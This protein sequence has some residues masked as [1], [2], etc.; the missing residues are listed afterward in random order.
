M[1]HDIILRTRLFF[2]DVAHVV[3][4][5]LRPTGTRPLSAK[6]I[7]LVDLED[8]V[9]LDAVPLVAMAAEAAEVATLDETAET[10]TDTGMDDAQSS[11]TGSAVKVHYVLVDEEQTGV[12]QAMPDETDAPSPALDSGF[13]TLDSESSPRH[14]L[15]FVDPG[16]ADHEKLIDG[17]ASEDPN[18]RLDV[19]FL[20][21]RYD[22]V[23][24]IT[25]VLSE[26]SGL[27]AV[28][29]V[30]H[31]TDGAVKLGNTWLN[32]DNL[33]A[34]AGLVAGWGWSLKSDADLLFYG[35]DLAE[36]EEGQ[37]LVDSL[38]TLTGADVAA[39]TDD[40]GHVFFGG[41][42]ELEYSTGTIETGL[43]FSIEVQQ[44]WGHLLDVTVDA[45][46]TGTTPSFASSDTVSHATS[47]T[48]RLM[49]VGI[50]FGQDKGDSVDSVTYNGQSLSFVGAQDN[51]VTLG[52]RMEI[53]ALVAPDIGTHDVVVNFSG[54]N[55][56]G[57]TIGVM[58]F[59]GVDQT[60]ALGSFASSEGD[61]SAPSTNVTSATDELVFGVLA[62]DHNADI[63]LVPGAGQTEHWDLWRDKATGGGTTEAGAASVATSW[64]LP[65]QR[66][67]A[68][69]GVSIKP[70]DDLVVDTTNDVLDGNVNSISDLRANKGADGFISLREAIIATNNTAGAGE[71]VLPAGTYTLSIVGPGEGL[72]ATGDLDLLGDLTIVGDGAA[73]TII[74][75]TALGDRVFHA[76]AGTITISGV[77]V[78]NATTNYGGGLDISPGADVTVNES[79]FSGH[80]ASNNG[81]AVNNSGTLSLNDVRITGNSAAM[82]GGLFN[83]GAAT[84]DRVTIDDNSATGHGGGINT[85]VAGSS[86]SLT[87]VTLSGNT[88]DGYGGAVWATDHAVIV[89]NATICDNTSLAGAG[90]VH[91][92]AGGSVSLRNTIL[93]S[94]TGVSGPDHNASDPV[95]SLGGN[96]DS[97]N[98]AGL[99][100]PS[101]QISTN[102]L[103]AASLADN[104]GFTPTHASLDGS[105]A[106]NRGT[107][108]GTPSVDQRGTARDAAPDVGAYE[109]QVDLPST[110]DFLVNTQTSDQQMT[111]WSS[112]GSQN[113]VAMSPSGDYVV[114][115]SSL[116]Q[117]GDGWGVY[118][119]RFDK[120]GAAQGIEFRISET[121]TGD[122]QDASVAMDTAGNFVV[123]WTAGA[124]GSEDVYLR[125]YAADGTALAGEFQANDTTSN[126]QKNSVVG[127]NR[128]TGDFVV[129]WQGDGPG[130]GDGIF[131]RRFAADGTPRDAADQMANPSDDGTEQDPSVSMNASG[132]FIVAWVRNGEI[133]AR[134]FDDTGTAQTADIRI[135]MAGWASR[136]AV[137]L[138]DSGDFTVAFRSDVLF[139]WGVYIRCFDAAGSPEHDS[140]RLDLG[141]H[142]SPSIAMDAAGN[143]AVAYEG[144]IDGDGKGVRVR[145]YSPDHDLLNSF[146][147]NNYTTG[148]QSRASVTMLDAD[149]FV[150]AWSGE[151]QGD[152]DGVFARQFG[153]A[154]TADAL[155]LST[156]ADVNSPSGAPGLDSWTEGEVLRFGDPN[157]ELE[158][159]VTNGTF[160]SVLN[161]D[162][163][164]DDGN[165]DVDAVHYVTHGIT[166]GGANAIALQPGDLLVSTHE[167]E[168]FNTGAF[169]AS[170]QDVFLYRPVV[171]G[172]YS[173]G[174][175]S[176]VLKDIHLL[177]DT[178]LNGTSD[179]WAISLVEHD[180]DVGDTTLSE[181]DFL[182]SLQGGA[183]GN[184]IYVFHT[185]DVGDGTTDG[186]AEILIEG[187]DIGLT[188]KLIGL[189]LV[190]HATQIGDE[191]LSA[192]ELLVTP[193]DL[194]SGIGTS[195]IT[196]DCQDVF[197]LQVTETTL[198]A[199]TA[200]SDA[201]LLIDGSEVG[202][203][204]NPESPDALT[205]LTAT[206]NAAPM[207]DAGGPYTINE[208]D[209][210]NLDGSGSSD[211]DGDPLTFEWDL[212]YD[213]ETFGVD[214][215]GETPTADWATLQ[216]AGVDDDGTYTV[217]VRVTDG[218][219]GLDIATTQLTVNNLPPTAA[220][221][222]G[223]G[224]TTGEDG[225]LTTGNVLA[226]DT[227]PNPVDTLSVS[228]IDTTLTQGTVVDN[229]D[230]TFDYDPNGQFDSL[231]DGDQ[232]FDS[233]SYTVQDDEGGTDVATV[234]VTI[235]GVND[236]PV[237]SPPGGTLSY[238]ESSGAKKID[239]AASVSDVDST[240]FDGGT[241]TVDFATG[242][243]AND[244]LGT[245]S[246]GQITVVGSDVFHGA[247]LI[248]SF[249]GGSDGFTPLVIS[250]NANANVSSV[251][252]LVKNVTYE[253]VSDDPSATSRNI[254]FVLTDGDGGTSNAKIVAVNLSA[255]NDIPTLDLDTDDSAGQ[256]GADYAATL[257]EDGGPVFV[258]DADG[259][260]VDV[261]DTT[262]QS[263][264]VTITN[265][266][267]GVAES[268]SADIGGTGISASYDSATGI[269]SLTGADT[270]ANYEQVLG[271]I[272]YNNTAQDPDTTDRTIT[273][274]A[275]DGTDDSNTA[276]TTLAIASQNDAPIVADQS[277]GVME[278]TSNGTRVGTI[279]I[280]DI[281]S[282]DSHTFTVLGGTGAT[283]FTV[284]ATSGE[285]T[286]A[287]S[288]QL[289]RESVA[290]LTIQV[291]VTDDGTPILSD[292]A[293]ITVNLVDENDTAPIITPGQTLSVRENFANGTSVG[294]VVATDADTAGSLQGWTLTAGNTDGIFAINSATGEIAIADNTN[295]DYETT[296]SYSLTLTVSDGVNTSVPQAVTIA[297]DNVNEAPVNRTPGP[298]VTHEDTPLV[299]SSAGGN[300]IAVSDVDAGSNPVIATLT[301][302]SGTLTLGSTSGL[303]FGTGDGSDDPTMTFVGTIAEINHA[304]DGLRFD[305]TPDYNGPATIQVTV[306]DQGNVGLGGAK[307]DLDAIRITVT[308]VN[309]A[310]VVSSNTYETLAGDSLSVGA[311]GVLAGDEDVDGDD[312]T[313]ELVSGPSNG[314]LSLNSNGSFQ[315]TPDDAFVGQDVF[316]YRAHDGT[317]ASNVATVVVTVTELPLLPPE[318][319]S[320]P[321]PEPEPDEQ[322]ETTDEEEADT[323]DEVLTPDPT[324]ETESRKRHQTTPA[325]QPEAIEVHVGIVGLNRAD[326]QGLASE[327]DLIQRESL[328][329]EGGATSSQTSDR[330]QTMIESSGP[331]ASR[332][333]LTSEFD[334]S[335]ETHGLWQ[336]LDQLEEQMGAEFQ[337]EHVIAGSAAVTSV[338]LTVGYVW[339]LLRGGVLLSSMLAQMPAWLMVD[340]M[341]VLDQLDRK[342]LHKDQE[343]G[344]SLQEI[345]E[346]ADAGRSR[347]ENLEA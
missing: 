263:L 134:K 225:G 2:D 52:S 210:L 221:D 331:R 318:I 121:T 223:A 304:L 172:D 305:P 219:G 181:G 155:W 152:A 105:P 160:S 138:E 19:V 47:G 294:S 321:L 9:Y 141:D 218:Q 118:G 109:F 202:L 133:Y 10:L 111:D 51:S 83:Q 217:A 174:T 144:S 150:V 287:D 277:F 40:T 186:T 35:C 256:A 315:Y 295:L 15:V 37:T 36:S 18:R 153:A 276:T 108:T 55:H 79:V 136:P 167:N 328:R 101:D 307:V 104:G 342:T 195:G 72:A 316:T 323:A 319:P 207:A 27:D 184:D 317:I 146:D 198:V 252:D 114:V 283:A 284:N 74:D 161:L 327:E 44:D 147:V 230:G 286:V 220:D 149:N 86:V 205:L 84:L 154:E 76:H 231:N 242:G 46:S 300:A 262:L 100:Q 30:T 343:E 192:G 107:T 194:N 279:A 96:M 22:G 20:D 16:V 62:L 137:A 29:F 309:D 162:L 21:L 235:S 81:G 260:I 115:W 275:N 285:I 338:G 239:T 254:R 313:A 335:S 183:G 281:D 266:L 158:P 32:A 293:T 38:A 156:A 66:K 124:T 190:E 280:N 253:N 308:P 99:D 204:S 265:L 90:G 290:S 125:R 322:Q 209:A 60:T 278:N 14:E 233:F 106:I 73:T 229:D 77:S 212:N 345:I 69:G 58:T 187:N 257:A 238:N 45:T 123:T 128:V 334:Y 93:A 339:W 169:T 173:S 164:A 177:P 200:V 163:L 241:L 126:S 8:R 140:Q 179:I 170:Q 34:H 193:D 80:S 88:A 82:G 214:V 54:T 264:T 326:S 112:R 28:H 180:T 122:Q 103:L 157:W 120:S 270:V 269:L 340:P 228:G 165:A 208:G 85:S 17:L 211:P 129:A 117:D 314:T 97:A 119:Q 250:L 33:D 171:A 247:D 39:S 243:T 226:N 232:A 301:A 189:E 175:F 176:H 63:D 11:D 236:A 110:G 213:G 178:D 311:Q 203:D 142:T 320:N 166:I 67:W 227:D 224:F 64:S 98:T 272:N 57:A 23:E 246:S 116:N 151:G 61:S 7:E 145:V 251:T 344:E 132:D 261:D 56:I 268:L 91:F 1:L 271:T 298:Q 68:V 292:T 89:T 201:K 13:S 336:D 159:G 258:T 333:A 139:G 282:G 341:V 289:D 306:D 26:N 50:S 329:D 324:Y 168:T 71:I 48:D 25:A 75:A 94:N 92:F 95:I 199:T 249:T 87:N 143:F 259:S 185:V 347:D 43:A 59:S 234:T 102:P 337:F 274:V 5:C 288:N 31:G 312:L 41:D 65:L 196:A 130:D 135:D 310:P 215:V 332:I 12:G 188:K 6:R 245:A 148:D 3:C 346:G 127:M 42:W 131:F 330:E 237:I 255:I 325:T 297:I 303:T 302:T 296:P 222:S 244:R 113:A 197:R 182:F 70:V 53:W 191:L 240:A 216:A 291:Q 206:A 299:F 248:G 49:L 273:F 4:A 78:Q 24:Q 267:D